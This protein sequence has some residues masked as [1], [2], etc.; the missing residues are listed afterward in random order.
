VIQHHDAIVIGAGVSGLYALHKLRELGLSAR[1]FEAGTDIGGTWYWN[2]YPGARFDSE[3][4][5]YQYSFSQELLDQ[6]EWSEHFAGQ[7]EVER[8][9]QFVANKFDLKRDIECNARVAT[10]IY[11]EAVKSWEIAAQN[12]LRARARY[13]ICATG[14]LSAH[15]F[16]DYPGVADFTGLSLHS[17]R[18]PKEPVDFTGK[19]VGIIG[20]G[21]TAVQIIQTIAPEVAHLT[22]FQRTANW[23]T[24]LRNRPI[25]AEEQPVLKAKAQEIFALCKRTWAGFIHEPDPR[26]AMEVPKE[27]RWARYQE[28]YDRGG[29]A[30]WLGNYSDSFMSQQ[31][32]DEVAEFL[33]NKIRERVTD[34]VTAEKL[35]PKHTFGTKRCPGE[36][37]YYE[38]FNRDNVGLVDLRETP[39]TKITPTGIQTGN[40]LHELDVIIYATGFHSVTG[41]LLRM[42]IRGQH[43]R[44]L[45]EHWADG[46]PPP[47]ACSSRASQ[48]SGLSWGRTTRRCFAISRA[49]WR[50]TWNGSWSAFAICASTGSRP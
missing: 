23:C 41:E 35:I 1:V 40:D 16:P 28:L 33:A 43:G 8:Y 10:V 49:V 37:N 11:D 14:L 21:P 39:I 15:Q 34:P 25:T 7:P 17:A 38:T 46:P 32:A 12:G 18:W 6:W 29:F 31:A 13:V 24:P 5:T 47:W 36:K 20:T 48:T 2:R 27:E 22:V 19:R 4:Y 42:D 50:P 9:L 26:A 44:T 45:Q 30:L 3:S